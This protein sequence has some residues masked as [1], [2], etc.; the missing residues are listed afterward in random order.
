MKRY[1]G[2]ESENPNKQHSF[3]VN[4]YTQSRWADSGSAS[5]KIPITKTRKEKKRID[6]VIREK[7]KTERKKQ[8]YNKY[9]L[10]EIAMHQAIIK[11][12]RK[13]EA[14]AEKKNKELDRILKG[15]ERAGFSGKLM[16]G[17]VMWEGRE[18]KKKQGT[19]RKPRMRVVIKESPGRRFYV[20]LE[21]P[22]SLKRSPDFA[23]I[24]KHI[25]R[26]RENANKEA[27]RIASIYDCPIDKE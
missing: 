11:A 5:S 19:R 23:L 12:R 16:S 6:Q 22:N 10:H 3:K 7:E 14:E 8:A 27:N 15:L 17:N 9:K 24:C 13:R 2:E 18:L 21:V 25:G 4:T 20:Y 26:S 1:N